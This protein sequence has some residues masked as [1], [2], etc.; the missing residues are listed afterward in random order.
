MLHAEK[1]ANKNISQDSTNVPQE[2]LIQAESNGN[3]NCDSLFNGNNDHANKMQNRESVCSLD[4]NIV[5]IKLS[6][7]SFLK[8]VFAQNRNGE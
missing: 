8:N 3:L 1:N 2:D 6:N 7:Q 4:E 5:P